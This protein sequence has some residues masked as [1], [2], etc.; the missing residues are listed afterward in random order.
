MSSEIKEDLKH[1]SKLQPVVHNIRLLTESRRAAIVKHKR[2]NWSEESSVCISKGRE[3]AKRGK[4]G[5]G[6]HVCFYLVAHCS[7]RN[8]G[9]AGVSPCSAPWGR[10]CRES[11]ADQSGPPGPEPASCHKAC[12]VRAYLQ[13]IGI[14]GRH[15]LLKQEPNAGEH[16]T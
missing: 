3:E 7:G 12:T 2:L 14:N 5:V 8:W 6:E 11:L 9:Q 16:C 15:P 4:E 1:K 13:Y 10:V